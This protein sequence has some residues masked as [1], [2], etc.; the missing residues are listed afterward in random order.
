ME[1]VIIA[2][3]GVILGLVFGRII[4]KKPK[5]LGTLIMDRSTGDPVLLLELHVPIEYV[6]KSKEVLFDVNPQE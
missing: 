1:Y 2:I 6:L 3:I 4:P 5:Y